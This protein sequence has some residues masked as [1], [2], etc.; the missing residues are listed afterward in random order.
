MKGAEPCQASPVGAERTGSKRSSSGYI[1]ACRASALVCRLSR[2]WH[3]L[4][5]PG[6]MP[7]FRRGEA[8]LGGEVHGWLL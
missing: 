7:L 2:A 5:T 6:A 3:G 8:A 4:N 1:R